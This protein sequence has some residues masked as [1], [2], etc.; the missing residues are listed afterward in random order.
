M[1]KHELPCA[2]KI[3]NSRA[4]AYQ[5]RIVLFSLA[6]YKRERPLQGRLLR[7]SL[8]TSYHGGQLNETEEDSPDLSAS[9]C[10]RFMHSGRVRT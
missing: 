6:E 9:G 3:A 2:A 8:A 1:Q 5:I 10:V 4:R 7:K